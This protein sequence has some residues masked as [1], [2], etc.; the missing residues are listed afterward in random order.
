MQVSYFEIYLDK[1]RDLLDGK[2]DFLSQ[3]KNVCDES[4]FFKTQHVTLMLFVLLEV[5]KTNLAVHEDK[6][7]VPYVKV[8]ELNRSLIHII[9]NVPAAGFK[10]LQDWYL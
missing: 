8:G 2:W 6:N 10:I 4:H 7:R 3:V 9:F 1:I 5:S